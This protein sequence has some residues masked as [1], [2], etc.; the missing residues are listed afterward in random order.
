[1]YTITSLY[2]YTI[3]YYMYIFLS[4]SWS[5]HKNESRPRINAQTPS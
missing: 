2:V 4:L 3:V 5:A 1:M